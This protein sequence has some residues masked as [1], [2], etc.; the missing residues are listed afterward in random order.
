MKI[1]YENDTILCKWLLILWSFTA[2]SKPYQIDPIF[3]QLLQF[4][5]KVHETESVN[6]MHI[7]KYV[8]RGPPQYYM[9]NTMC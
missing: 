4:Q 2:S 3:W 9:V 7:D 6:M 5:Y 1:L 8:Y